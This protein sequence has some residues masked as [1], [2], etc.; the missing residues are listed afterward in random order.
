MQVTH[1]KK[2]IF[3]SAIVLTGAIVLPQS[4]AAEAINSFDSQIQVSADGQLTVTETIVYD[5]GAT[6]HHGI[7]RT[8][9]YH[10]TRD[11]LNYNVRIGIVS[12]VD[13][14]G[15]GYSY[16]TS[17]SGGNLTLKIGDADTY[18][19]GVHTYVITYTV[20][21]AINWFDSEPEVYWN[22]TGTDWEV[23]MAKVTATIS[24]NFEFTAPK[25]LC[26]TGAYASTETDCTVE[27]SQHGSVYI[28]ANNPIGSYEGLTV[29]TRL[30][31]GSIPEPS[32]L[33]RLWQTIQDNWGFALPFVVLILLIV[34]YRRYGRDP[35][36]RGTII[37][38]YEPPEGMSPAM[39][40][41]LIDEKIDPRDVSAAII[42][43]AVKGYLRIHYKDKTIGHTY[44]LERLKEGD[45]KL[46]PFQRGLLEAIFE[47]KSDVELK[48]IKTSLPKKLKELKGDLEDEAQQKKFFPSA[49]SHVRSTYAAI[50]GVLFFLGFWLVGGMTAL[51]VGMIV[52]GILFFGFAPAMPRRTEAGVEAVEHIKGF[53]DFLT[54]TEKDR[55][56]FHQAPDKKPDQFFDY[57][58]YAIA[59]SV[60]K[61]WAKQFKDITLEQP[62]WYTGQ[63]WTLFNAYIF[64]SAMSDFSNTTRSQAITPASSAGAGGSGFGGGGFSGGGFGGGGG[65]SW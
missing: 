1:I 38:Q 27:T 40:G 45:E 52:S 21:R 53:K 62:D 9:P 14:E 5:F 30:P 32:P 3:L 19:S 63:D 47:K 2:L 49:P 61:D 44:R 48:D 36:G 24:G 37:A 23:P 10:Y 41:Y 33:D 22:V 17:R 51:G 26:F 50:G 39:L 7:Y 31:A 34:L 20:D 13:Y 56:K 12:V 55:V 59:L 57:L 60:E 28:A 35:R 42:G 4:A 15:V 6:E 58:P 8:I 29:V 11:S 25:T 64:A 65:G 43:L 16:S 46:S 18:I 54:V